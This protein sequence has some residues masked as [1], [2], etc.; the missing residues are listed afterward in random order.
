MA[1][2]PA[3]RRYNR[4]VLLLSIV[5]AVLLFGAV[6]LL[7]RHLVAG[8]PAYVV[9]VLPALPVTGF[10]VAMG[11]YLLEENDEYLRAVQIRQL[12]IATGVALAASTIWGFLE[13]FEL[14][15]HLVAYAWPIVWFAG[16][17]FGACVNAALMRR[18]GQ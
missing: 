18:S 12:L 7:S 3:Q 16:L 4:T 5:Y 11:R 6:Y 8:V 9:G 17:G 14:V 2:S 1:F 15:P 13:G 10:F